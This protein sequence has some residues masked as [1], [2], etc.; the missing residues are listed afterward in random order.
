MAFNGGPGATD[1]EVDPDDGEPLMLIVPSFGG[2]LVNDIMGQKANDDGPATYQ[3]VF[4]TETTDIL[5]RW[6]TGQDSRGWK[7]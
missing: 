2:G 7:A 3:A 6:R 5:E 4:A 1:I